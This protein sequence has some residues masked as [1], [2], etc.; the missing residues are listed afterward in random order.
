V[1]ILLIK[2]VCLQ[3]QVGQAAVVEEIVEVASNYQKLMADSSSLMNFSDVNSVNDF[4]RSNSS[5]DF[6]KS[7]DNL[8]DLFNVALQAFG[9]TDKEVS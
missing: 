5:D 8:P 4:L 1:V 7:N 2:V 3:H 9:L 6:S